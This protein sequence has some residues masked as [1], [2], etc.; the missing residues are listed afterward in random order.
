MSHGDYMAKVPEG[1]SLCAHSAACPTVGICDETRKIYG[2]QFHPEVNHTE[3]GSDHPSQLLI[4]TSASATGDWTMADYRQ[5][6]I[7]SIREKVGDGKALLALSGGVDSSV[8]AALHGRGHRQ[9]A[10]LRLCRPRPHAQG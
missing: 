9:S 1:F 6:A 2:V 8:A 4:S 10:D 3:E 7:R 5:N